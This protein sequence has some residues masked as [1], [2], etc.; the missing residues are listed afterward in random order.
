MCFF[1]KKKTSTKSEDKVTKIVEYLKQKTEMAAYKLV[2]VDETPGLLSSKLGGT[3]YWDPKEEFPVDSQGNKMQLLAQLNFTEAKLNDDRL[4]K[5][6]ILQ[7]FIKTT[8]TDY[9]MDTSAPTEQTG[10]KVIYHKNIDS[11][12]TEEQITQLGLPQGYG[13]SSTP[14]SEPVLLKFEPAQAMVR[15]TTLEFEQLFAEAVK[16]TLKMDIE[17]DYESFLDGEDFDKGNRHS[18]Q[19]FRLV[20]DPASWCLGYPAFCQGDPRGLF[21]ELPQGY[22][23][24]LL[25][26]IDSTKT[27]EKVMFGD[28][29]ICQFMINDKDLKNL[30]FTKVF[31]NWDCY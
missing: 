12:I 20:E 4:P 5:E 10:F 31:Y 26:Q 2:A 9:G 1:F 30:D 22:F 13:D 16:A 14:V 23:N 19:L 6:G 25:L 18:D 15:T 29:G 8:G 24:T 21:R 17:E 7:F 28:T 27:N 3:P 11:S